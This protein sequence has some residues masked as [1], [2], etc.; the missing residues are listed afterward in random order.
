MI[1]SPSPVRR[2]TVIERRRDKPLGSLAMGM[3]TISVLLGAC[4]GGQAST[5]ESAAIERTPL[6]DTVGFDPIAGIW[7]AV[8]RDHLMSECLAEAGYDIDFGAYHSIKSK[9]K[10]KPP[11]PIEVQF[12]GDPPDL[13]V[14]P[15]FAYMDSFDPAAYAAFEKVVYGTDDEP[16]CL[17]AAQEASYGN[18]GDIS[19]GMIAIMEDIYARVYADP[20]MVEAT[21]AW[22]ACMQEAGFDVETVND[23]T[24]QISQR[25]ER[26]TDIENNTGELSPDDPVAQEALR[27][28]ET[29]NNRL[30]VCDEQTDRVSHFNQAVIRVEQKYLEDNPGTIDVFRPD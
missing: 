9:T 30:L 26:L 16:G 3:V 12:Y 29:I 14:D 1:P 8:E 6:S 27:F 25:I 28:E 7:N 15:L 11:S 4:S 20:E 21:R 19:Q 10:A 17:L 23:I 13:P 2:T 22:S 24:D 5:S 18:S